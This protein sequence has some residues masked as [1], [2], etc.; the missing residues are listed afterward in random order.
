MIIVPATMTLFDRQAWWLPKWLQWIPGLDVEGPKLLE[1]LEE[2][3]GA[4]PIREPA[5]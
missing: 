4:A 2:Q 1:H 3:E 5:A